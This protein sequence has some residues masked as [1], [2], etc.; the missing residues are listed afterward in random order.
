MLESRL[1]LPA[2]ANTFLTASDD[3]G[4]VQVW[5]AAQIAHFKAQGHHCA[6]TLNKVVVVDT[7][8]GFVLDD[9]GDALYTNEQGGKRPGAGHDDFAPAICN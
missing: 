3:G 7:E 6:H 5:L 2:Q 9:S 4:L 1:A 8:R